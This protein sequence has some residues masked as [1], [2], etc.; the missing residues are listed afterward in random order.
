M[1]LSILV[2]SILKVINVGVN[3]REG[4]FN[5]ILPQHVFDEIV[6]KMGDPFIRNLLHGLFNACSISED[7]SFIS[8]VV[9]ING[10]VMSDISMGA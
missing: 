5:N 9:P 2:I 6:F 8:L 7:K 1:Y 3:L 10:S 4:A